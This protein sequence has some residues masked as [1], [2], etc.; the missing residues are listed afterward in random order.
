MNFWTAYEKEKKIESEN[1]A[2]TPHINTT[3]KP[4]EIGTAPPDDVNTVP[5]PPE[6]N[7]EDE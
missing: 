1:A 2:K 7:E 5:T 3:P 6:I 4:P